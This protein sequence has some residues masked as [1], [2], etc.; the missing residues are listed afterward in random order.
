MTTTVARSARPDAVFDCTTPEAHPAVTITAL[1]SDATFGETDG[2]V[3]GR[4]RRMV[5]AEQAG[6]I[7]P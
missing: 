5:A 3:D 4:C 6:R 2:A 1:A 7:Y